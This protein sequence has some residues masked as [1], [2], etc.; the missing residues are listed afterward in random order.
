AVVAERLSTRVP[1]RD[2]M[3]AAMRLVALP[4][5]IDKPTGDALAHRLTLEHGV[6]AYVTHHEGESFVRVCGQLYNVP[7]HYDRL[8]DELPELVHL[9]H[10]FTRRAGKRLLDQRP[11]FLERRRVLRETTSE[12]LRARRDLARHRVD[13][14]HD[15]DESL[16]AED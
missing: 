14:H 5:P 2:D 6:T 13:H 4:S 10:A 7:E 3:T 15:R 8:A 9:R 1:I 12:D 11:D 16:A